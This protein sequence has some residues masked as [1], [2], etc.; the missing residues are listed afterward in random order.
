MFHLDLP[1][2]PAVVPAHRDDGPLRRGSGSSRAS[3]RQSLG[4]SGPRSVR[5]ATASA[6]ASSP[7]RNR[8]QAHVRRDVRRR[9][10]PRH[11]LTFRSAALPHL[12]TASCR[13]PPWSASRAVQLT[14]K[15]QSGWAF[16]AAAGHITHGGLCLS[17]QEWG[18]PL[19]LFSCGKSTTHQNF[20]FDATRARCFRWRKAA[21]A[22]E[23]PIAAARALSSSAGARA[24]SL[25]APAVLLQR[26]ARVRADHSS[27]WTDE[28]FSKSSETWAAWVPGG[29]PRQRI[30]GRARR[31][32][33]TADADAAYNSFNCDISRARR[34]KQ[35]GT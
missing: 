3:G 19:N 6:C 21:H 1:L 7:G 32:H 23:R 24:A 31:R 13:A 14:D 34:E 25:R 12:R 11:G 27:L 9:G 35:C 15:T 16:D 28:T 26:R 2:A 4:L 18:D 30:R 20:T 17:A 29:L 10:P 22:T 33:V 8:P 5:S